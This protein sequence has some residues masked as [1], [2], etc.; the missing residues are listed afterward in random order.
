MIT[1]TTPSALSLAQTYG[2]YMTEDLAKDILNHL[3]ASYPMKEAALESFVSTAV[4]EQVTK[5]PLVISNTNTMCRFLYECAQYALESN[6]D[7]PASREA[8]DTVA[9]LPSIHHPELKTLVYAS[10]SSYQKSLEQMVLGVVVHDAVT[11]AKSIVQMANKRVAIQE[12]G[13]YLHTFNWGILNDGLAL[14]AILMKAFDI[15]KI[16]RAGEKVVAY[17]VATALDFARQHSVMPLLEQ[18]EQVAG[19]GS[20][21]V[22]ISQME[23]ANAEATGDLLAGVSQ[24]DLSALL[25]RPGEMGNFINYCEQGFSDVN[26]MMTVVDKLSTLYRLFSNLTLTLRDLDDENENFVSAQARQ[27]IYAVQTVVTLLLAGYE[28]LRETR[29][30]DALILSVKGTSADPTVDVVVNGDLVNAYHAAGGNDEDLI[31]FGVH[32]DP[33]KGMPSPNTGWALSFVLERRDSV[34][35]KI[36]AENAERLEQLRTNDA[37]VISAETIRIVNEVVESYAEARSVPVSTKVREATFALA[38]NVVGSDEQFRLDQAITD[39]LLNVIDDAHLT[40][41][42]SAFTSYSLNAEDAQTAGA[43]TIA[44]TAVAD[45]VGYINTDEQ[46]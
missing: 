4:A 43:Q 5:T 19:Y 39:I 27:R 15:A 28:A 42:T 16:F 44:A 38:R 8:W 9:A 33:R 10:A 31:Y 11:T 40:Q 18:N 22:L 35:P 30:A 36:L 46:D 29:Y 26:V 7:D 17:Y 23:Q 6:I 32:L 1:N 3:S 20:I 24:E 41:M 14:N 21:D 34:I 2:Q 13:G 12:T 37:N 25:F 45:L